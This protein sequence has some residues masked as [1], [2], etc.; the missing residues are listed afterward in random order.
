MKKLLVWGMLALSAST[1]AEEIE[2]WNTLNLKGKISDEWTVAMEPESR[3]ARNELEYFHLDLGFVYKLNSELKIGGYF[4]EI[5]EIKKEERVREM[6]PH[7][8]IFYSPFKSF[9]VRIRNEYQ[10]KEKSD[11]VFRFRVRPTYTYKVNEWFAPFIQT[12][13]FFTE[14]GFV[15]NRLN[16]GPGFIVGKMWLKPGY[17]LQT[18]YKNSE[19]S[20]RHIIWVNTGFKF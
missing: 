6:R 10:I 18:D 19:Y 3:F 1:F 2:S 12:E 20:N 8:D 16:F 13:P 4:R 11:N 15:R 5:F 7:V 14:D 17:M 9:K